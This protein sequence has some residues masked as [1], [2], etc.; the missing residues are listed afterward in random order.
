V[1]ERG[2]A[3]VAAGADG[4]GWVNGL[5]ALL[6]APALLVVPV[7]GPD[8]LLAVGRQAG[9]HGFFAPFGTVDLDTLSAVAGLVAAGCR[10]PGSP[11]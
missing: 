2:G 6:D 9:R 3:V 1:L 4:E 10:T 7:G 5:R 8:H 11:P